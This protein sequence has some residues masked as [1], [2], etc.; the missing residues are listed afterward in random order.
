MS[1]KRSSSTEDLLYANNVG[2]VTLG[3]AQYQDTFQGLVLKQ[4]GLSTRRGN[5][6]LLAAKQ[7]GN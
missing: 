6:L 2:V 3:Q 5:W 7:R 4:V 1:N